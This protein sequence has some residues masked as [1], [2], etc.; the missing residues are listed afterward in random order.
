MNVITRKNAISKKGKIDKLYS[1]QYRK[2]FQRIEISI[3]KLYTP[4]YRKKFQRIE[5]SIK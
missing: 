4:Q 5:I 3:K 2:K 1:P